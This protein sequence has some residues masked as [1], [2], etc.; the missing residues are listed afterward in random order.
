M[1]GV[2]AQRAWCK[3]HGDIFRGAWS[4]YPAYRIQ[5]M[6]V[7]G[8][9]YTITMNIGKYHLHPHSVSVHFT[10]AL[11]P[12]AVFFLILSY[13]YQKEFSLFAY[14]HLMI[15]ATISAA[16]SY[17]TGI[18]EWKRKYKGAKVRVFIR[19]DRFGMALC[20]LGAVCSLW[21]GLYPGVMEDS[22][23]VQILFLFLNAA[24]VPI[25]VYLG[26]LG[27]RLVFGGAH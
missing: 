10:S 19:K 24:L 5:R 21:Y 8:S 17:L 22:G 25:I 1:Q 27:G 16:A 6:Q 11:Y 18:M 9:R 7:P 14:Y 12:V 26:Y 20:G 4:T 3:E 23:A 13:F 15:I 2:I